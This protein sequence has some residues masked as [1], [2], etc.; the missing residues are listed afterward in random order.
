M[1]ARFPVVRSGPFLILGVAG[2][3]GLLAGVDPTLALVGACGVAFIA[4]LLASF[5]V[6]TGIFIV[7]TFIN[8][9][10]NAAKA[11]GVLLAIALLARIA[12]GRERR[13]GF[14]SDHAVATALLIVFLAWNLAGVLWAKSPSAVTATVP[15]Y[16][17]SVLLLFVVYAAVRTRRDA[18]LLIGLFVLGCAIAAAYGLIYAP[19]P[20]LYDDLS[21]S[22]GTLGDPN[23]LAAV[24]VVGLFLGAAFSAVRS[25]PPPVRLAAMVSGVLCVAGIALSLSRGGLLALGVALIVGV[26]VA[27]RWRVHMALLA[28][29]V[30]VGTV[31][32]FAT[33]SSPEALQRITNA[34]G[35][36]G[37]SD[38][39]LVGWRMFKANPID[40]VGAGNFPIVSVNYLLKPGTITY[41]KYIV[42]TPLVAHNTYLQEMA[43][44]GIVGAAL[45][46][47][48]LGFALRSYRL[49]WR[50]F[51]RSGDRDLEILSYAAFIGLVGFLAACFFISIE[52][53]KQLW[54][55]VALAPALQRLSVE[56]PSEGADPTKVVT[57]DARA[58]AGEP[59]LVGI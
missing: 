21:R 59:Q 13:L 54:I 53:S 17:L 16:A 33:S 36:S 1:T 19:P 37:R 42:N 46:V 50:A 56:T 3:L 45:F 38:I 8:L 52:F 43:E 18:L 9:P 28:V 4:V 20:G 30:A 55:L 41:S 25:V 26:F 12:M 47:G 14:H 2:C 51:R 31:G 10:D 22:G 57:T 27:G 6:A 29:I 40:G 24:L 11:I 34:G 32:Y 7:V 15:R 58:L 48:I 44:G 5:Q 35:G 49:A 39:W 23:E